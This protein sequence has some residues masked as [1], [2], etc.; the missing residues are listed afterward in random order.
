MT[1]DSINWTNYWVF[2]VWFWHQRNFQ[3]D[4]RRHATNN[5]CCPSFIYTAGGHF[6]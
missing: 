6:M 3:C 4:E 1:D 5:Q 2:W